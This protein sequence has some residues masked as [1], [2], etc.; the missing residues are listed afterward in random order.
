MASDVAVPTP[1]TVLGGYL[2]AGKTTLLN[3]A[4]SSNHPGRL[5]VIVNDFGSVN[6]DADLIRS[7]TGNALELTNGC[8]CCDLADGMAAV[9]DQLKSMRPAPDHVVVEVSGVG[10]PRAVASWAESPGFRLGKVLVCVDVTTVRARASDRW[11]G[12][13]V[14]EQLTSAD[15]LL[16]TKTDVVPPQDTRAV[17]EW[18]E[19]KVPGVP[20]T[21]DRERSVADLLSSET[22]PRGHPGA[23]DADAGSVGHEH[24]GRHRSYSAESDDEVD[25]TAVERLLGRLPERTMRVKG[26]LRTCQ[27]PERRTVVH[28]AGSRVEISDDGPWRHG[29]K[30]A[31]VLITARPETTPELER[32]IEDVICTTLRASPNP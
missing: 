15:E 26:V 19:Q 8:V 29:D 4:L 12:D 14:R 17:R 6:I 30:S 27:E 23:A 20:A 11:V 28:W 31:L 21:D 3:E 32:E 25:L 7:R 24:A 22:T 10:N 9:M 5:A 16:L 13:T 2:G 1:M 18:L